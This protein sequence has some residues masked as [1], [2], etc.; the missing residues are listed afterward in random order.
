M[1]DSELAAVVELE[2]DRL[3]V[4]GDLLGPDIVLVT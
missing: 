1:A 2:R 4:R 3:R